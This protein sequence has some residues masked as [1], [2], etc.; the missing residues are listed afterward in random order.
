MM[1][2]LRSA[3]LVVLALV[4]ALGAALADL[5]RSTLVLHTASGTHPFTVELAATPEERGTGLMFR[6]EMADDA[7]MLF[8]FGR[9]GEVA[10]WMKNTYLP[11]D[12]VFIRADGTVHRIEADTVPESLRVIASAGPVLS[13]LE[14]NAGTAARIG[15]RPGD[16][17][18]HPL[19]GGS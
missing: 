18:E 7:G 5:P 12:M 17:V 14:L 8:D 15:L 3:A 11:L 2:A 10:M 13:V 16:R 4:A 1:P 19:F 9:V 6:T